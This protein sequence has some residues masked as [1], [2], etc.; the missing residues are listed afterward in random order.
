M[1]TWY[2]FM[3][4]SGI[5]VSVAYLSLQGDLLLKLS[6]EVL[7]NGDGSAFLLFPISVL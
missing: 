2:S 5:I 6:E 7:L 3:C 1:N 4:S